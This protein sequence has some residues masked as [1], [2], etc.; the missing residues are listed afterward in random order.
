MGYEEQAT[1]IQDLFLAGR[2]REAAAAV[3]IEF[4]DETALI[5][6]AARIASRVDR[7]ADAGVT[8]LTVAPPG[9]G[10]EAQRAVLRTMAD[11]VA[12]SH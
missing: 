12:P 5:G 8:T 2:H 1:Q 11:I 6:P 10:V 7:Y 9:V 4:I 3:P